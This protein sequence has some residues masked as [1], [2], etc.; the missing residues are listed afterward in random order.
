MDGLLERGRTLWKWEDRMPVYKKIVEIVKEDL[1]ILYLAKPINPSAWRDYL[2]GYKAE[3]STWIVYYR[4]GLKY[5]W[6]DK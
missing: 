3:A 6:F 2:S 5:A 4:G 1:P